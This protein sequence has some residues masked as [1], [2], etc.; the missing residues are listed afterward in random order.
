MTLATTSELTARSSA[1]ETPPRSD[2]ELLAEFIGGSEAAFDE[3]ARRHAAMVYSAALRQVFDPETAE[4]VTSAVFLVLARKA[5]RFGSNSVIPA[6]LHRTARLASLKAIRTRARRQHYEQEATRMQPLAAPTEELTKWEEVAPL[7][8]EAMTRLAA[9]DHEAVTLRFFQNKSF[10]EI[11]QAIGSTE[12]GARKRV[13]RALQ[14]LRRFFGRRG[15]AMTEGALEEM[16]M[17]RA[18]QPCPASVLTRISPSADAST[19][20]AAGQ[21]AENVLRDLNLRPWRRILGGTV[22]LGVLVAAVLFLPR[23]ASPLTTL[24]ALNSAGQTG[25]GPRWAN[26]VN[27]TSPAEDQVRSL[28]SSNILLQAELRRALLQRFG[29][30][31]YQASS[32]PRFLDDLSESDFSTARVAAQGI[33]AEIRL[34]KGPR[35]QFVRA[36]GRWLFDFFRTSPMTPGQ[37]RTQMEA[38]LPKIQNLTKGVLASEFEEIAAAASAYQRPTEK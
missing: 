34:Q 7:L 23:P 8:D 10:G 1:E 14:K 21:L 19:S 17:H 28:L 32:F 16:A 13:A 11:G 27:V 31:A 3:L 24:R 2:G 5:H 25:D 33:H 26:L 36:E 20:S 35:L 15:V 30:R 37:I 4:E 29:P 22:V 18:V 38:R 12:E 6:W 9:K